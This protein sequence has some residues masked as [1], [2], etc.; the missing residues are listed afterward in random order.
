[1]RDL[2]DWMILA[3]PA[4]LAGAWGVFLFSGCG[5]L[6]FQQTTD[7]SRGAVTVVNYGP[8]GGSYT[9]LLSAEPIEDRTTGAEGDTTV[10]REYLLTWSDPQAG[11][12]IAITYTVY[13]DS[14]AAAEVESPRWKFAPDNPGNYTVHV[15]SILGAKSNLVVIAHVEG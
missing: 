6:T 4:L 12:D 9:I 10:T 13:V 3:G 5:Q 11:P 8:A 2:K 1:M 14:Q 7:S 15:E